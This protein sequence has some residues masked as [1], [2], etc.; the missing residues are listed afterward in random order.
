[1]NFIS[2]LRENQMFSFHCGN[3]LTPHFLQAFV[4]ACFCLHERDGLYPVCPPCFLSLHSHSM[5]NVKRISS[6]RES[7]RSTRTKRVSRMAVIRTVS[8]LTDT[9]VCTRRVSVGHSWRSS[10]DVS[11]R[12]CLVVVLFLLDRSQRHCASG[13]GQR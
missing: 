7:S 3:L 12:H 6:L 2:T 10:T 13:A 1:M 8:K 5:T 9:H 11:R 4:F